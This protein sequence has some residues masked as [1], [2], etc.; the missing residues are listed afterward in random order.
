MEAW[1]TEHK[2]FVHEAYSGGLIAVR[3]DRQHDSVEMAAAWLM[4]VVTRME[5]TIP[6]VEEEDNWVWDE[7]CLFK[8]LSNFDDL[9][10]SENKCARELDS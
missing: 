6:G 10:T 7:V 2:V 8:K 4:S 9:E 1:V 5:R 3:K